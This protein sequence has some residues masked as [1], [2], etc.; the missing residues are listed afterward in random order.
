MTVLPIQT[1]TQRKSLP[2][3]NFVSMPSLFGPL[4]GETI[5]IIQ[6]KLSRGYCPNPNQTEYRDKVSFL[7]NSIKLCLRTLKDDAFV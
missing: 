5:F 1:M 6:T 3:E 2:Y 7:K 4:S